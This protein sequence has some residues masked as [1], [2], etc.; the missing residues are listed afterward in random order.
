MFDER[1]EGL[2]S[3]E[4]ETFDLVPC[5]DKQCKSILWAT[6]ERL[7]WLSCPFWAPDEQAGNE[8]NH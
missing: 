1:Y 5:K 2:T 4:K 7:P 6:I 8:Y 3:K